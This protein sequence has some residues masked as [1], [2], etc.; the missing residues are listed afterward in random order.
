MV[1]GVKL[2]TRLAIENSYKALK[3]GEASTTKLDL[4]NQMLLVKDYYQKNTE[5]DLWVILLSIWELSILQLRK[6]IS[7][8]G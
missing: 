6:I 4:E 5:M 8:R 1:A 7:S 2:G 3:T